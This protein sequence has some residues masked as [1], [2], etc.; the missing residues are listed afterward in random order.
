MLLLHGCQYPACS[1]SRDRTGYH[2][3]CLGGH[4]QRKRTTASPRSCDQ[5]SLKGARPVGRWSRIASA[6]V[7]ANNAEIGGTTRSI[8]PSTRNHFRSRYIYTAPD[9][10]IP[11]T[12]SPLVSVRE[13]THAYVSYL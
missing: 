9:I 10:S 2:T 7:Q 12:D 3:P 6:S 4:G 8:L 1:I 11:H 13:W 5:V